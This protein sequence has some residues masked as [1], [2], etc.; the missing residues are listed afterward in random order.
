[1]VGAAKCEGAHLFKLVKNSSL[2]RMFRK[3][4]S[5]KGRKVVHD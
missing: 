1:M 3:V 2:Y 5:A 4:I